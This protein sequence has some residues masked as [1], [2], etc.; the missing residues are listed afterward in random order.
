MEV[1]SI[2][3]HWLWLGSGGMEIGALTATT[4]GLRA[5]ERCL[6]VLEH[7]TG[8]RMNHG[9]VRPGGLATD[10]P[11]G[12]VDLIRE[13]LSGQHGELAGFDKLLRA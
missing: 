4:N 9:Y 5:R 13:W 1:N 11:T 10:L 2:A 7:I 3:S 12:T 6:E 8:L